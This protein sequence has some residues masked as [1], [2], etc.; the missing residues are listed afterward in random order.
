MNGSPM[1]KLV[2][3]SFLPILAACSH[4]VMMY[5]RGGGETGTGTLNDGTRE[6]VVTLKGK[7]FS[8]KFVRNQSYG[9]GIGQS[10]GPAPT[11]LAMKPGFNT[12]AM[13]GATNQATAVLTSGAEVLRCELVVVNASD[14]SGVCVDADNLSYDVLIK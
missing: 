5:P 9:F 2:L 7:Q 3:L 12:A 14:G 13:M 1:L 4:T 8:G 6:I 11:G 10:F